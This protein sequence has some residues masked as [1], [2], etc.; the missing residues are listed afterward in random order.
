MAVFSFA[1]VLLRPRDCILLPTPSTC[2]ASGEHGRVDGSPPRTHHGFRLH[3]RTADAARQRAQAHGQHA[4]PEYVRQHDRE[5]T[6]PDELYRGLGR[7]RPAGAAVPRG[8]WRAGGSVMD[9]AIVAEEIARTQ[10][11]SGDGLSAATCS[12][13]STSCA[14]RRR[15]R[16]A[17]GCRSCSPARSSCRSRC[18]SPMPAPTSARC[19]PPRC[20]TATNG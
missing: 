10:R 17:I 2:L 8:I 6:Y 13:A 20:A 1:C 19:A 11:R 16:S 4:P 12:A 5:R 3:R 9:M 18:R 14:R 7:G 15:S